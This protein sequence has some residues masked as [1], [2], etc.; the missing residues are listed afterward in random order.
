MG[1]NNLSK[2]IQALAGAKSAAE[3]YS[4]SVA[5]KELL[6]ATGTIALAANEV[7]AAPGAGKTIRIVAL[8]LQSESATANV[9]TVKFGATAKWRVRFVADGGLLVLPIPAGK[10]LS[11]GTNVA[12]N[13]DLSATESCNYNVL[14]YVE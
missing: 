2:W 6:I 8:Q 10:A 11:V 5:D 1:G 12:L 3:S 4:V 7:I 9:A 13:V 14:Y